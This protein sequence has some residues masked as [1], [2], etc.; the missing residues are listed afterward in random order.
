[1]TG[2][3]WLASRQGEGATFFFSLHAAP[4]MGHPA[5]EK[6]AMHLQ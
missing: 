6:N 2:V 5:S 3:A 4:G 1:M